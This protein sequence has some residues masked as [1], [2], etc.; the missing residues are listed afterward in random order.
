MILEEEKFGQG[1]TVR[2]TFGRNV[3]YRILTNPMLKRYH[4]V[5]LNLDGDKVLLAPTRGR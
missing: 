5:S 4:Q 2:D 1:K 3:L